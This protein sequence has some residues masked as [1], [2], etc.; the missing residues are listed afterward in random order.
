MHGPMSTDACA[1]LM[2]TDAI[3][4]PDTEFSNKTQ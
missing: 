1:D 4:P 3:F 2:T